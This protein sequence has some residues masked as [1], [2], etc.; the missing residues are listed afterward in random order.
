MLLTGSYMLRG[1]DVL[2][3]TLKTEVQREMTG[4]SASTLPAYYLDYRV[5]DVRYFQAATSFG[6]VVQ[7]DKERMR[8]LST[9]VKVGDYQLDNTHPGASD[10]DFEGMNDSYRYEILPVDDHEAA[11]RFL[12]W[13][14]TQKKYRTAAA[15]YKAVRANPRTTRTGVP[16]FT[17]EKKTSYYEAPLNVEL[18]TLRWISYLKEFSA[19]FLK[20]PDIISADASLEVNINR[21]YFVSGVGTEIVQNL[22][23]TYLQVNASV[24][25]KG[26]LILPLSRSFFARTPEGLPTPEKVKAEL[27]KMLAVLIRLKD[28]PAAEPYTGPAILDAQVAGVFFHEIFGHRVE[29]HR[30]RSDQDGQTFKAKLN[31]N[32]LPA[33]L[34]VVFDPTL[35]TQGGQ[36]L[37]GYYVFDD[38]GVKGQ[39][40]VSVQNG[41]LKTFLMSRAPVSGILT[42][43]GHGRAAPG[44]DVVTRQSNLIVETSKPLRMEELRKMLIKE[45]QRQG[46][47]YGYYFKDV[48]G[49]FT[50]TDRFNPNAFN[51]FPTEVYRIYANGRP[52]ELV[53]GVD[54][55]GT[56]LAMFAEIVAAGNE[57]GVFTGFCGAESGSVPVSAVAP[58]LF[59]RRIETQKKP[60]TELEATLLKRPS[61]HLLK[62]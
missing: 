42:S 29:G 13:Q 32:V 2:L 37:N 9:R 31:E 39:R 55:I 26:Q 33:T 21:K 48:V 5:E 22:P 36:H 54:L 15:T 17:R 11:L 57:I 7:T 24:R 30:L 1:Q 52:D 8:V 14:A 44:S 59:V 47:P 20:D 38:E 62:K 25:S 28:A 19:L 45:C 18:D 12:I 46:R 16:D 41:V 40:V 34:S 51:I 4:L 43:N 56:P 53:Q 23:Y 61:L 58:A 10:M 27:E 60:K 6:S 50:L 3:H 35:Q 49:G